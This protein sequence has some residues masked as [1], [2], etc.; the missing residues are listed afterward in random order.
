MIRNI[1][2]KTR[3]KLIIALAGIAILTFAIAWN[4]IIQPANATLLSIQTEKA[5]QKRRQDL[6]RDLIALQKKVDSYHIRFSPTKEATWLIGE[7]NRMADESGVV[8]QSAAPVGQDEKGGYDK[9][10]IRVE[11]KASYHQLGDFMSRIE[12]A[13]KF[14]KVLILRAEKPANPEEAK[15][16]LVRS[17]LSVSVFHSRKSAQ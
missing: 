11:A 16:G 1:P 8:L 4:R 6:I 9:I 13:P 15:H 5:S 10:T 2:K 12:S 3:D 7:L 14:I 17:A